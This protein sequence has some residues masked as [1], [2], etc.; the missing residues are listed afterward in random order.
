MIG[1]Q[2]RLLV[3]KSKELPVADILTAIAIVSAIVVVARFIWVFP[4]TS[5]TRLFSKRLAARDPLPSWRAVVVIGFTGI[6][7]VV[8]LAV[9]LAVPLTLPNGEVIRIHVASVDSRG[10]RFA[11]RAPAEVRI[12]H[13]EGGPHEQALPTAD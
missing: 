1:F 5:L 12:S 2:T 3:E 11:I 7:G 4:G 9:A 10:V 13:R 6:R 8:S